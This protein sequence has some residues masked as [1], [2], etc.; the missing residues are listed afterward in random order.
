[1]SCAQP[2]WGYA[3]GDAAERPTGFFCWSRAVARGG[4]PGS[5]AEDLD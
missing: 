1:M 2:D 4:D 3:S 5:V